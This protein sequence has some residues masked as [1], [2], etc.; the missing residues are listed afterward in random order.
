MYG[1]NGPGLV[2]PITLIVIAVIGINLIAL[3]QGA[4]TEKTEAY[5]INALVIS[6]NDYVHSDGIIGIACILVMVLIS[7]SAYHWYK[8]RKNDLFGV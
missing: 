2:I 6:A 1:K 4:V 7:I 5:G 8:S 3:F